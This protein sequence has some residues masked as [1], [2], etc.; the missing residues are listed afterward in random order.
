MA[1]GGGWG[2]PAAAP[3]ILLV[4]FVAMIAV[5]LP[6][7]AVGIRKSVVCA[8]GEVGMGGVIHLGSVLRLRG[9]GRGKRQRQEIDDDDGESEANS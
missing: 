2:R 7:R 6:S 3:L 8:S 5:G 4:V 9:A 1:L